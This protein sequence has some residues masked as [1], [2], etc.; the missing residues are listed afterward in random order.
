MFVCLLAVVSQFC[1]ARSM[2]DVN[3]EFV[4]F[5]IHTLG[6]ASRSRSHPDCRAI[7]FEDMTYR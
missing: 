3:C 5:R 1:A 2:T 6:S 7:L 4:V